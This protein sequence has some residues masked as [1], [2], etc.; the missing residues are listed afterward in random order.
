[1]GKKM[2]I[3]QKIDFLNTEISTLVIS[4]IN[5]FHSNKLSRVDFLNELITLPNEDTRY[6]ETLIA[7]TIALAEFNDYIRGN[8][9]YFKLPNFRLI[10]EDM[11]FEYCIHVFLSELDE[12]LEVTYRTNDTQTQFNELDRE[13]LMENC[14]HLLDEIIKAIQ[15]EISFGSLRKI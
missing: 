13:Y 7:A 5:S 2:N 8:E 15:V 1:M 3:D 10:E 14:A 4:R 12:P 6:N 9:V 11:S